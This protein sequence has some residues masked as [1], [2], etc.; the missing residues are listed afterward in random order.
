[1]LIQVCE[2]CGKQ[3]YMARQQP[4]PVPP[5]IDVKVYEGLLPSDNPYCDECTA[6]W[7][8]F[9]TQI[10]AQAEHTETALRDAFRKQWE[11]QAID[12]IDTS[13]IEPTTVDEIVATRGKRELVKE[14]P[15]V[16]EPEIPILEVIDETLGDPK[17]EDPPE[18]P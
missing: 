16:V 17:P 10:D 14:P 9:E 13:P 4:H 3:T 12:L 18:E 7:I 5:T 8:V 1:M 6:L 15:E 11:A 2:R